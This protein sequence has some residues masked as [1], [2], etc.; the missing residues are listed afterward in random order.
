MAVYPAAD[1]LTSDF[2]YYFLLFERLSKIADISTV[3]QINN[4]HIIPYQISLPSLP[5]QSRITEI[6]QRWDEAIETTERLVAAK[7]CRLSAVTGRILRPCMPGAIEG[8]ATWSILSF[9][10]I[11]DEVS[12]IDHGLSADRVITVGK[13][14]I[15]LQSEHFKRSVASA[16]VSAYKLLQTGDFVYDPMS[17]YYGALGRYTGEN[18]GIVSP[19]YRVLKLRTGPNADFVDWLLKSH[20]VRFQLEAR[21]SQNNKEGKRRLLQR[22]EFNSI[23]VR[24]PPGPQQ[25]EMAE[26][27]STFRRDVEVTR[28]QLNALSAQKRGLMQ[29]MLTGEWRVPLRDIEVDDLAERAA[30]GEAA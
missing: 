4:K 24:L 10:D 27:L 19:A 11:F 8:D 6:L 15:R 13:Y 29:K 23:Q 9:G 21:S 1:A 20:Y 17:A 5:E 18:D 28:S 22:D 25:A 30:T 2:L 3:P 12:R 7:E 14:A 26:Q 16:D